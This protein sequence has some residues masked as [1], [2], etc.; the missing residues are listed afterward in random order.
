MAS[1]FDE[2]RAVDAI[3]AA[4]TRGMEL[5]ENAGSGIHSVNR[6]AISIIDPVK[7]TRSNIKHFIVWLPLLAFTDSR[8]KQGL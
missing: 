3:K 6:R 5:N 8:F 7:I 4:A 1:I 2:A